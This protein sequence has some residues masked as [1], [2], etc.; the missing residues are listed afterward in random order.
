MCLLFNHLKSSSKIEKKYEKAKIHPAKA[1]WITPV[2][3][4]SY[5]LFAEDR[6]L[7]TL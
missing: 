6:I 2:K 3:Y 1:E 7:Y 4:K 5:L